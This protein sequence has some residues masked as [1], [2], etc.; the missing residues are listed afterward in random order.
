MHDFFQ[1]TKK[2]PAIKSCI[3]SSPFL[4]DVNWKEK[5]DTSI[6]RMID[7][8]RWKYENNVVDLIRLMRNMFQHNCEMSDEIKMLV[9]KTK[10]EKEK[11][12]RYWEEKFPYLF[13]ESY[14]LVKAQLNR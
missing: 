5:V 13:T 14:K 1:A 8:T 12:L 6:L 7:S 3:E 11:F 9:G 2:N 10:A 4:N